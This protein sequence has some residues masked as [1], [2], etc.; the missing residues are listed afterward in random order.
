M[1]AIRAA[2]AYDTKLNPTR[3]GEDIT[4]LKGDM[5]AQYGI[6]A[7]TAAGDEDAVRAMLGVE[8]EPVLDYP[9]YYAFSRKLRKLL[10]TY[11]GGDVVQAETILLVALWKSRGLTENT[12]WAIATGVFTI[13]AP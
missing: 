8:G 5:V 4:A 10:Q 12:L 7:V 6:S 9:F 13:P 11:I 3:V 2:A 1:D